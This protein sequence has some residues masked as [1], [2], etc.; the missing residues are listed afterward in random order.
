MK[1]ERQKAI[2]IINEAVHFHS[3]ED[4]KIV[5]SFLKPYGELSFSQI[6]NRIGELTDEFKRFKGFK[7]IKQS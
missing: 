5:R 3:D 6:L 2:K 4:K 7:E 1:E